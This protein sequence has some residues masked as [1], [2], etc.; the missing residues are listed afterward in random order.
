M[1]SRTWPPLL[2]QMLTAIGNQWVNSTPQTP[3]TDT[4]WLAYT[5]EPAQSCIYKQGKWHAESYHYPDNRDRVS[6]TSIF[7]NLLTLLSARENLI[8][9][10][11]RENFK[12]YMEKKLRI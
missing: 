11:R 9:F 3:A 6:E 10:Y 5:H 1:L 8:E 7:I 4:Y 12:S 2:K